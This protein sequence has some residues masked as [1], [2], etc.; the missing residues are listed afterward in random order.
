M[1]LEV[2]PQWPQQMHSV[3]TAGSRGLLFFTV[4]CW[5]ERKNLCSIGDGKMRDRLEDSQRE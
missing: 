4:S 3:S 5:I 2:Q 1:S